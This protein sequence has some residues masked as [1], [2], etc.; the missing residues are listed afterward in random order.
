ME[1]EAAVGTRNA[2]GNGA[3]RTRTTAGAG[4]CPNCGASTV[5]A[6]EAVVQRGAVTVAFDPIAVWWRGRHV[7]L[8][9]IEARLYAHVARRG[10]VLN[11]ELDKVLEEI[12]ASAATR[13]LVMGH[14]RRK[15]LNMGAC[16]PFERLGTSAV[17]L[18]VDPDH[19]GRT[20]P[21]IG[22]RLPRYARSDFEAVQH[23]SLRTG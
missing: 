7:P 16:D 5:S 21:V 23:V 6:E 22:V 11:E 9:P 19:A 1:R 18:R 15:F 10:R 3:N 8:S 2:E 13:S 17:R 12:G 14:I 20:A 4:C